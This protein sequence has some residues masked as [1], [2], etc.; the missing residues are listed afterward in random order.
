MIGAPLEV[1]AVGAVSLVE[2]DVVVKEVALITAGGVVPDAVEARVG[3][4]KARS[5]GSAAL[6]ARCAA[7]STIR[8]RSP[9]VGW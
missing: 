9:G 5:A 1:V 6:T 7:A 8:W 2:V 3:A 4:C